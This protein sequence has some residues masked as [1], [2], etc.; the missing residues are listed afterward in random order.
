MNAFPW[1]RRWVLLIGASVIVFVAACAGPE[2]DGPG[3][4]LATPTPESE[5]A[6]TA[7]LFDLSTILDGINVT[8]DP[9]PVAESPVEPTPE[10]EPLAQVEVEVAEE[11]TEQSDSKSR[12][13][14]HKKGGK[15]H[16]RAHR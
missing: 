16:K 15:Q 10:P 9:E 1:R 8:P 13:H 4:G 14:N 7:P 2:D 11:D 12:R 6:A 5:N 3:F